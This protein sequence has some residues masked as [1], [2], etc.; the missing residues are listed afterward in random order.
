MREFIVVAEE[1]PTTPE[2]S[3]DD[4]PGASRVDLLARCVTASF[5]LS[6][7]LR[8]DVRT[9]LV[10]G[11]EFTV[12]FESQELRGLHPDERST[13][14]RI[15]TALENRDE[16]I[17]HLPVETS[18]GVSL[19]RMGLEETLQGLDEQV[20]LYQLDEEGAPLGEGR[21]SGDVAFVL[22]NHTDLSDEAK[23]TVREYADCR[24]SVGPNALHADHTITVVHNWLDRNAQG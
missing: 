20:S 11:D 18:P 2:F 10:V 22:S 7:G 8:E 15:R 16:A 5:L 17:G 12:Q 19:I 13:A 4:L 14:A 24:V 6:H 23:T 1:G 3:L 21:P 9:S